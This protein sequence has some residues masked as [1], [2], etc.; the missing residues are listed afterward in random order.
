M[1]FHPCP[2]AW[3][4]SRSTP[5]PPRAP[6][7]QPLQHGDPSASERLEERRLWLD[8]GNPIAEGVEHG[9]NK[10]LHAA[11]GN[12][13]DPRHPGANRA[14]RVPTE[15]PA[16]PAA[17]NAAGIN[18]GRVDPAAPR[19]STRT[20][21]AG[22]W[23]HHQRYS[24]RT[25]VRDLVAAPP[26]I[27]ATTPPARSSPVPPGSSAAPR[28][29]P[30]A[31]PGPRASA[32]GCSRPRR[33]RH[34]PLRAA[35][36]S[37]PKEAMRPSAAIRAASAMITAMKVDHPSTSL[38]EPDGL[39]VG[40]VTPPARSMTSWCGR[41]TATGQRRRGRT[42]PGPAKMNPCTAGSASHRRPACPPVVGGDAADPDHRQLVAR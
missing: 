30:P 23:S 35:D 1:A 27:A 14:D 36:P 20:G 7:Q 17:R 37:R 15:R 22:E 3:R 26:E 29:P 4:P 31:S 28:P 41:S 39:L 10:R 16:Q 5:R 9:Q 34:A 42:S 38:P 2:R 12:G 33:P 13:A 18:V 6:A 32:S 11:R 21:S 8:R 19:K 24:L 25:A 40:W